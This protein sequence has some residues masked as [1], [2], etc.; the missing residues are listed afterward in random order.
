MTTRA[1]AVLGVFILI[2]ALAHVG[3]T[4]DLPR[5]G[6]K[7]LHVGYVQGDIVYRIDPTKT[8]LYKVNGCKVECYENLVVIYVDKA[9]EPTWT[10]NYVLTIPWRQVESMTLMP[11]K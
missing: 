5:A 9:K 7:P 3:L 6:P 2:A 1:A 4:S 11:E 8:S 10:N